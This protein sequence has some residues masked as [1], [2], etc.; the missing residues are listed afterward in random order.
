MLPLSEYRTST[1]LGGGGGALNGITSKEKL[2]PLRVVLPQFKTC[3]LISKVPYT[4]D[5]I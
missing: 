3:T 1:S 4:K 2:S 5:C